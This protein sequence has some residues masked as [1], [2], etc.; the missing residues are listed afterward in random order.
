[1]RRMLFALLVLALFLFA[2][3]YFSESVEL[4]LG[5]CPLP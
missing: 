3:M 4:S 5:G 1:M 2:L